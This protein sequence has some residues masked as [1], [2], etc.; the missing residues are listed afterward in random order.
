MTSVL[1]QREMVFT[2]SLFLLCLACG[3]LCGVDW[4]AKYA[5]KEQKMRIYTESRLK[6]RGYPEYKPQKSPFKLQ[7]VKNKAQI[8]DIIKKRHPA[9]IAQVILKCKQ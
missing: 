4:R 1:L 6:T 3:G 5:P 9:H 8:S 7:K 2:V